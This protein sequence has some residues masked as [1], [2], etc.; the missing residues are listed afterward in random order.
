MS[1]QGQP[2]N[3]DNEP[4]GSSSK[5]STPHSKSGWDGKLRVNKQAILANPEALSDPEYSDEDAP[6]P[7]QIDA[8]EDL[9]EGE[10]P[11][12]EA[13]GSIHSI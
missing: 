4:N 11:D 10:D 13:G 8:D 1:E 6:P 7:E 9:L 5:P 12:V 2:P 3:G